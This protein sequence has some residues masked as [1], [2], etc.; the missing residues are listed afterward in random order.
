METKR[1]TH[2]VDLLDREGFLRFLS[3]QARQGWE[4]L[5]IGAFSTVFRKAETPPRGYTMA[6]HRDREWPYVSEEGYHIVP[7]SV[8]GFAVYPTDEIVLADPTWPEQVLDEFGGVP[9][10]SFTNRLQAAPLVLPMVVL[11]SLLGVDWGRWGSI[12]NVPIEGPMFWVLLAFC[13]VAL[14]GAVLMLWVEHCHKKGL[15]AARERKTVYRPDEGLTRLT[16][17]KNRLVRI[18]TALSVLCL[19]LYFVFSGI[20]SGAIQL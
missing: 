20:T 1:V 4:A 16:W 8:E 15:R 6:Y 13:L 2:P 18:Q 12:G 17:G 5:E 11:L 9:S 14:S 7:C 10:L 3:D 19:V